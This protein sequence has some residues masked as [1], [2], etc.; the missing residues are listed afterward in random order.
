MGHFV[1]V[2]LAL[3]V[4]DYPYTYDQQQVNSKTGKALK[5]KR[6]VK[7]SV[8]TGEVAGYLEDEY[9]ILESWWE[10]N[11]EM[12]SD[13]IVNSLDDALDI[14]LMGG[15]A[16]DHPLQQATDEIETLIKKALTEGQPTEIESLIASGKVPTQ[17]ALDGVSH[18]FAHPYAK[19]SRRPSFVDRGNYSNAIKMWSE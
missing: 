11:Q 2:N 7:L 10:A 13:L 16:P 18:R 1:T 4:I 19:R 17:A 12:A 5:K 6:T 15:P 14:Q 8:T 3:G 9:H